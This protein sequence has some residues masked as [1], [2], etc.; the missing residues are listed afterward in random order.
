MNRTG[1]R[2]LASG[3]AAVVVLLAGCGQSVGRDA[4]AHASVD[5]AAAGGHTYKLRHSDI[6][7]SGS[8]SP[9]ESQVKLPDGRRVAM[10]YLK[11]KRLYV[12]DYSPSARGWSK[13]AVV[14]RAQTDACQGITLKA[15]AGTVAAI[16]DFGGECA[17]RAA[18]PAGWAA[19]PPPLSIAAVATGRLTKWD[20]H[21]TKNF[22]G[23]AKADIT[24]NGK[25][26]TFKYH[27]DRLK[28]TKAKGFPKNPLD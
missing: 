12:Q 6:H 20:R 7:W 13:P 11:N 28:W 25:Q 5:R 18:P 27:S 2:A 23:W 8:P 10:H 3:A 22:D 17:G 1:T 16:A 14:Y 4:G 9:F 19:P 24:A 15:R 21:L 26:V